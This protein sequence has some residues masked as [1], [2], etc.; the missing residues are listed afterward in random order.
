MAPQ[1]GTF[2]SDPTQFPGRHQNPTQ[3]PLGTWH[4]MANGRIFIL[5]IQSVNGSD[6]QATFSSGS[7]GYAKWE[8][9]SGKLTFTRITSITQEY[10]GY[11][12]AYDNNDTYWR[13][14]GVFGDVSVGEQ[15]G[16]YATIP[17]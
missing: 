7:I 17:K 14:A 1:P 10:R 8:P 6:V 11:L 3:L 16:W 4:L 2:P 12:M 13:L 15:A 5:T 9:S